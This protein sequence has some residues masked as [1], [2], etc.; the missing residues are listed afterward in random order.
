MELEVDNW[1]TEEMQLD[2]KSCSH[3]T[4]TLQ[5]VSWVEDAFYLTILPNTKVI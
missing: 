2:R 1:Q 5:Q 3:F 4:D